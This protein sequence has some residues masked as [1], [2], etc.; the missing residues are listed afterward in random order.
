MT[1]AQRLKRVF[2]IDIEVCSRC[3]GICQSHRRGVEPLH[4]GAGRH[5]PD[6]GPSSRAGNDFLSSNTE[7][8]NEAKQIAAVDLQGTSGGRDI[9]VMLNKHLANMFM[10][11]LIDGRF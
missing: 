11:E 2:N 4:R 7:A 3:G 1:W 5:H 10:L 9:I 6:P 8:F